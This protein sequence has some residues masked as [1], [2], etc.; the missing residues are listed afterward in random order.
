M[1][2]KKWR[3]KWT[4]DFEVDGKRIRRVSPTQSKRGAR[5]FESR[6]RLELTAEAAADVKPA[7]VPTLAEFAERWLA[8][9]VAIHQKP[10]TQVYSRGMLR[11]HLVP[12][13]GKRRLD[14][15]DGAAI[16]AF[17][18]QQREA[19]LNNGSINR[20]LS[21]LRTLLL[22]AREQGLIDRL[23][24]IQ[25][26]TY[27]QLDFDWLRPAE[28]GRLLDAAALI[29]GCWAVFF[30][31]AVRTGLRKGELFGLHWREV[32]FEARTLTVRYNNWRGQLVTPKSGKSRVVPMVGEVVDALRLW[33]TRHPCEL[34]FP[35]P[36]GGIVSD[37]KTANRALDKA[38]D[39][40]GLRRVRF[41]DLRHTFASHLVLQGQSLRVVQLLMGHHSV[42]VTERYAH[43]GAA[44]LVAAVETL[45]GLGTG[46]RGQKRSA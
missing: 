27:E 29:G 38:L 22:A 31:V 28:V 17:M 2:V 20:H 37:P 8:T 10:S 42:T 35:G 34:V 16:D 21:T 7:A 1:A 15:I 32:D 18:I 23:V 24:P 46:E 40:A 5:E 39:R 11:N 43:V 12:F 25:R 19:G 44:Q 6:L 4:V 13:F 45:D 41:H 30:L 9:H 36:C 14:E 3:G 26:L 33:R